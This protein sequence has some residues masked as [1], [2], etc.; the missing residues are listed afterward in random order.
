MVQF[1]GIILSL[2]VFTLFEPVRAQVEVAFFLGAGL[3]PTWSV[4]NDRRV[5]S[6]QKHNPTPK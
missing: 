2:G 3:L 5:R 4:H 1:N 6:V